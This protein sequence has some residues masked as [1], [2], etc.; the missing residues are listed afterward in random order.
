MILSEVL[1]AVDMVPSDFANQVVSQ[2]KPFLVLVVCQCVGLWI[3]LKLVMWVLD[4]IF[5]YIDAAQDQ[6]DWERLYNSYKGHSSDRQ[7]S[8]L[9]ADFWGRRNRGARRSRH[10]RKNKFWY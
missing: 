8:R 9:K 2:L 3:G 6:A 1:Q 7:M 4:L 10:A 5:K